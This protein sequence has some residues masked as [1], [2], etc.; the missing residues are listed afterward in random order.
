MRVQGINL[1]VGLWVASAA[2]C[3]SALD[4]H[5][6]AVSQWAALGSLILL[7]V[8][9][10]AV[11][12]NLSVGESKPYSTITFIPFFASVVMFHPA[13][14][15][16]VAATTIS[17]SEFALRSKP[18]V[19]R[20][21]NLSQW[22]VASYLSGSAYGFFLR[23]F[24]GIEGPLLDSL[25]RGAVLIPFFILA[26]S[27]FLVN[28][29]AVAGAIALSS[30]VS[31]WSVLKNVAGTAGANLLYGVLVSPLALL[32]AALGEYFWGFLIVA[33]LPLIFVRS[34]YKTNLLLKRANED[35]LKALV[36]AIET[37]DPY[38]SGHS[39][40]VSSLAK[41]IA[42]ALGLPPRQVNRIETAALLHDIGKIDAV[43]TG[44]LRKPDSLSDDERSVMESH[45]TKGVELLQ[46]LSSL[47][48]SIIAAVRHH[49]EREDGK[50]YPD[51]LESEEIPVGAKIIKVC[52]AV[53]AMLSDR[54]YR[55][56]LSLDQ[57]REQLVTYAGTQFDVRVVQCIISSD[58]LK[59]HRL[60]IMA[61][62]DSSPISALDGHF[63]SRDVAD[64]DIRDSLRTVIDTFRGTA[65][66]GG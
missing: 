66:H 52:D 30:S 57:V 35:L 15:V 3:A 19:K 46:S 62:K 58:I 56:A 51:G 61:S 41:R 22:T 28:Y 5:S 26:L 42:R 65:T 2:G 36:K 7:G 32:V 44:I 38:T 60:E 27:F 13:A 8:F 14:G 21:F 47:E 11:A 37:R 17:V 24:G 63:P 50:G 23:H 55:D 20:I 34:S 6:L 53:D 29:L 39:L 1:Y 4:W 64:I 54:P 45:V 43:Y 31:F 18:P 48:T 16:L 10:E 49:H 25:M 59:E 33:M 12:I 40:R 9:A